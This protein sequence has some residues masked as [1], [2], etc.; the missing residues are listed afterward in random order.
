M[1]T[2]RLEDDDSPQDREITSRPSPPFGYTCEP[3]SS[4]WFIPGRGME[5]GARLRHA[6]AMGIG[7]IDASSAALAGLQRAQAGLARDATKIASSGPDVDAMI[8]PQP[9]G[10]H[11]RRER[12]RA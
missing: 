11:V 8:D 7:R 1:K 3:F 12:P 2:L 9:A 5:A 6:G 10:P 4:I